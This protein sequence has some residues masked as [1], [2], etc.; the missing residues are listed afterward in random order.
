ME[1]ASPFPV[2]EDVHDGIDGFNITVQLLMSKK[3]KDE[4]KRGRNVQNK[5]VKKKK[6]RKQERKK[7]RKREREKKN[8]IGRWQ[9]KKKRKRK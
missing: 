9:K 6:K 2:E 3:Q 1:C 7:K 5:Q 8:E 4:I